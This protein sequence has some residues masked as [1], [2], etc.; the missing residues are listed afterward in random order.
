MGIG[1]RDELENGKVEDQ[2]KEM[3]EMK[4]D[5]KW[6]SIEEQFLFCQFS[7]LYAQTQN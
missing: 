7:Q 4:G 2:L 3:K 1:R 5:K 6:Y